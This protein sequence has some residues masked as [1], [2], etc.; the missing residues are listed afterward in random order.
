MEHTRPGDIENT[1][2]SI[3]TQELARQGITLDPLQGP[4]IRRVIHATADFDFAHTLRFTENAVPLAV[5]ALR[6]GTPIV[7]DTNMAL[8][9]ISRPS[10]EGLGCEAHCLMAGETVIKMARERGTTRAAA[11][12]ELAGQRWPGAILAVGNAPT[13]LLKIEEQLCRGLRPA[14]VIGVPVGFVNVVES[15]E[16]LWQTCQAL[17]I[18]AIAAMGRKG[19]STVAVAIL[20]ALLYTAAGTLNPTDRG[21]Q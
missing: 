14:L 11:A 18:P 19:G 2:M 13:A 1:S 15:K 3:I 8:A 6:R 17:H 4:I 5:E 12:M 9:G 20:N 16:K 7:T 21:W 10:L